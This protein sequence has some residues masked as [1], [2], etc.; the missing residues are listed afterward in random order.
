[1]SGVFFYADLIGTSIAG[2]AVIPTT[3]RGRVFAGHGGFYSRQTLPEDAIGTYSLRLQNIIPGS[4][5]RVETVSAGTM[6]AEGVADSSNVT[7]TLQLYATGSP[8]NDLR[9]KVRNASGTPAYRPFESQAVAQ[10]GTV[11]IF[12]FQEPDE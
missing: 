1:M 4:R 8:Y 6:L 12:V 7:L 2:V 11:T 9:I 5:Y 10:L 3:T